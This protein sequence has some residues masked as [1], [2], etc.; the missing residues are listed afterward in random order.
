[1]DENER[2]TL[3]DDWNRFKQ[4]ALYAYLV[5]IS[6]KKRRARIDALIEYGSKSNDGVVSLIANSIKTDESFWSEVA[7][8]TM[9]QPGILETAKDRETVYGEY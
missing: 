4:T 6:I 1:M 8:I 3:V 9:V 2:E 5:G 7:E